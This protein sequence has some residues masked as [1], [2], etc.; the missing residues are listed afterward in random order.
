MEFNVRGVDLETEKR[1]YIKRAGKVTLKVV[2]VTEGLSPNN[3]KVLKVHFQ[4]RNNEWAIDEFVI[5]QNAMWKLKKIVM[6]LKLGEVGNTDM[7]IGRYVVADFIERPTQNNGK[8]Y[9]IKDYFQSNL[10]EEYKPQPE[11]VIEDAPQ[12]TSEPTYRED[13]IPF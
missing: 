8:I 4:D 1:I 7:F 11:I 10:T 13:E 12:T 6:A 2:K 5:T 9:E 3:N